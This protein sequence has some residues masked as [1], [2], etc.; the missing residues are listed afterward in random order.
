M[1]IESLKSKD[2]KPL[3]RRSDPRD[4]PAGDLPSLKP[5]GARNKPTVTEHQNLVNSSYIRGGD[6]TDQEPKH[7]PQTPIDADR[8]DTALGVAGRSAY[9]GER[10]GSTKNEERDK[11]VLGRDRWLVRNGH[12]V[13]YVCLYLFSVMVLF[14]PYEIVPGLSFLSQTAIYFAIATL[15]IFVPSQLATEGNLTMLSTEVK[16]ILAMTVI[17]L[18]SIPIAK[19]PVMAWATFSDSYIKAVA[20]FIVLVNVVRTRKRLMGM[21]WLSLG[22]GV[23]LACT[24]M[25]LFM[26]G[27]SKVEGYRVEVNVGGMFGN[28][29]EMALHFVMM[30]PIA[31]ALGIASKGSIWRW[32]YFGVAVLFVAGNMV[33]FSRGGF[34]GLM[35][36]CFVLVWKIGRKYRLN[37]TIATAIAGIIAIVA[38]PGN[39]G[40]RM[41]SIFIPSLDPVGS[42]DQRRELLERSLL[43]SVRQPWGIGIGNFPIVGVRNQ[44]THNAFT[45]VSTEL[46][47]LG[48]IAYLVFMISPFRKLRAIERTLFGEDEHGWF[49]YLA[50]GLQASIIGYWVS[51]FFASVAYNWFIYY[52]I[53]YAVAFRRIYVVENGLAED[54]KAE[55]IWHGHTRE[56]T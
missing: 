34:I 15:A 29:N 53:A 10:P 19:D 23:Y 49:Y 2:L 12:L 9:T 30:T 43:V 37:V 55:P 31:I 45:Q 46:G 20:I 48:L 21:M 4:K 28:P 7:G 8:V 14:R 39:Y 47:I 22:I 44:Q 27:Q 42:S 52:L 13:T 40:L 17:A 32:I 56:A 6:P 3:S 1:S 50:I 51:S 16:A 36:C 25:Y 41:L 35:A 24:A 54:V 5:S 11:E 18:I 26:T 38:A 33:T